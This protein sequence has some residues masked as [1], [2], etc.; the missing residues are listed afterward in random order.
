M[1]F[2]ELVKKTILG[3][4]CAA[5]IAVSPVSTT[6]T[7]AANSAADDIINRIKNVPDTASIWDPQTGYFTANL[8]SGK[9]VKAYPCGVCEC[10]AYVNELNYYLFGKHFSYSYKG[11]AKWGNERAW[12]TGLVTLY[13]NP[14][15]S[16][17]YC[18]IDNIRSAD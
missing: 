14:D 8:S 17:D 13:S 9:K 7:Y 16:N 15:N 4:T 5:M 18:L 12:Y 3:I 11:K 10:F 2:K 6:K 1:K